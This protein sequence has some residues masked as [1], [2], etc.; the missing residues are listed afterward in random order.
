MASDNEQAIRE[1]LGRINDAWLKGRPEDIPPEPDVD[2]FGDTAI[3][4]YAWNMTYELSGLEYRE[5][6][7][8]V[9]VFNRD[10]GRWLAVWR[11][12]LPARV[13]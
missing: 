11:V 6:G 4:V 10:Q 5:S 3:A 8:D 13:S 12:M 2:I 7:H 1:L 9:F